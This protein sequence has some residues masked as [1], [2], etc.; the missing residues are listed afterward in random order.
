MA[1]TRRPAALSMTPMLE[2][3]MPFPRPDTTPPVTTKY[4]IFESDQNQYFTH[5]IQMSAP[6][7]RVSAV[8]FGFS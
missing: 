8:K 5:A 2:I 1:V 7:R 3:E 4:F 6:F